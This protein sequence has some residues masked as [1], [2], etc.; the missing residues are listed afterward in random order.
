MCKWIELEKEKPP[1]DALYL[2]CV[3]SLDRAKPLLAVVWYDRNDGWGSRLP[4][5]WLVGI[6]DDPVVQGPQFPLV[7]CDQITHWQEIKRPDESVCRWEPDGDGIWET[8]CGNTFQFS[9]SGPRDNGFE[10]C[11]Y[12][13]CSLKSAI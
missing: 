9:D 8:E 11:P 13:G 3:E 4:S 6:G 7:W 5:A 2:V 10:F 1:R 12:C